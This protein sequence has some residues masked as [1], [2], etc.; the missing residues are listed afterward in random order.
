MVDIYLPFLTGIINQALK[1]GIFPDEL[2]LDEVIPLFKK[3]DPYDK[4]NYRPVSLLS[5]MSKVFERIIFYQINECIEPFLS[6]LR[7]GFHKNQLQIKVTLL[8]LS[9]RIS[10]KHSTP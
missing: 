5:H 10:Q 6:N 4:I 3:V 8:M 9:S 1:N 2:K 7:T